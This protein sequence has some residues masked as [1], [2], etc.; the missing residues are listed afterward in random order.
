MA[1]LAA[2]PALVH[3]HNNAE[4]DMRRCQIADYHVGC[5]DVGRLRP[6]RR[7]RARPDG[8]PPRSNDQRDL[9]RS[10]RPEH[11][12]RAAARS[13]GVR[14]LRAH[15]RC[16]TDCRNRRR[17]SARRWRP[18]AQTHHIRPAASLDKSQSPQAYPPLTRLASASSFTTLSSSGGPGERAPRTRWN[19]GMSICI[20]RL[21]FPAVKDCRRTRDHWNARSTP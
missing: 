2:A 9:G 17:G 21:P 16:S 6:S 18:R 8:R 20:L 4:P 3:L 1:V 14:G 12:P 11:H 19:R 5:R 13:D 10:G 7:D 15:C